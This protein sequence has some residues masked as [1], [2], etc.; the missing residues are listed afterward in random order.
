[1]VHEQTT[2]VVFAHPLFASL[3]P[4]LCLFQGNLNAA[5]ASCAACL[6]AWPGCASGHLKMAKILRARGLSQQV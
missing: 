4:A 2:A 5:E 1:M 3:R 6:A